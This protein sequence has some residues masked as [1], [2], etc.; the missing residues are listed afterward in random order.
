MIEPIKKLLVEIA[1]ESGGERKRKNAEKDPEGCLLS[2]LR[3]IREDLTEDSSMLKST[4][5]YGIYEVEEVK[6]LRK[7]RSRETTT[8]NKKRH[9]AT[10]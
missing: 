9:A 10:R 8:K 5:E 2:L 4:V 7:Q 6:R 3:M 1:E